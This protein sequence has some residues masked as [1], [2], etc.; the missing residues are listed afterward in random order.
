MPVC[1]NDDYLPSQ[2]GAVNLCTIRR[3]S[4]FVNMSMATETPPDKLSPWT[5]L[6]FD[7]YYAFI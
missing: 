2:Q 6:Y 1:L 4:I 7:E 3:Q 5:Y